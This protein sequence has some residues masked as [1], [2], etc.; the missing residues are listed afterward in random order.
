MGRMEIILKIKK[1]RHIHLLKT[2]LMLNLRITSPSWF[3]IA[4]ESTFFIHTISV[5]T[6][7][8]WWTFDDF[9]L[10][11]FSKPIWLAFTFKIV[12]NIKALSTIFTWIFGAIIPNEKNIMKDHSYITYGLMVKRAWKCAYPLGHIGAVLKLRWHNFGYFWPAKYP[13]LKCRH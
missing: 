6:T 8:I 2:N 1:S 12:V 9:F 10:T 11:S 3:A 5:Y 4:K 7:W 13:R